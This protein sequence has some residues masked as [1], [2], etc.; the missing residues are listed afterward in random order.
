[1]STE[2]CK[3]GNALPAIRLLPF[4]TVEPKQTPGR[5]LSTG[6]TG[7]Q[8]LSRAVSTAREPNHAK[9]IKKN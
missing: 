9:K 3:P 4:V 1:M 2:Q 5:L 7:A 8:P 6:G